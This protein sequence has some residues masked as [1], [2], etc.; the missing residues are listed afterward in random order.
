MSYAEKYRGL[1]TSY[2]CIYDC[3]FLITFY[4]LQD[5]EDNIPGE[6]TKITKKC[7]KDETSLS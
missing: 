3:R 4:I 7:E 2:I 5:E 6:V 1:Y